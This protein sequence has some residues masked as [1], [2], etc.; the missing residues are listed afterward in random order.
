MNND[1]WNI[2]TKYNFINSDGTINNTTTIIQDPDLNTILFNWFFT[3]LLAVYNL[4]TGNSGSL[5]LFTYREHPT[6]TIL[7]VTFTFFTVIYLMNLFIGLLNLA[8]DVYNKE[9]E[10]LL[11]KAQIIIEIE[12]F[13]MLPFQK[14]NNKKCLNNK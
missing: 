10:F 8:I 2:A 1:L 9:E 14:Y 11:Q 12:L 13:Y 3:F 5:L 7:L 4:L 6:I